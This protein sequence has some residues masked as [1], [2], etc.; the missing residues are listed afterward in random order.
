MT[1][2]RELQRQG[3]VEDTVGQSL[4]IAAHVNNSSFSKRGA[5]RVRNHQSSWEWAEVEEGKA[6]RLGPHQSTRLEQGPRHKEETS[7]SPSS[8][9]QKVLGSWAPPVNDPRP[10]FKKVWTINPDRQ[11]D[12]PWK[13]GINEGREHT[14]HWRQLNRL[15]HVKT[16]LTMM[17]RRCRE[18]EVPQKGPVRPVWTMRLEED[19][20]WSLTATWTNRQQLFG[21]VVMVQS[22]RVFT[23]LET[24]RCSV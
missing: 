15:H 16:W 19:E 5:G 18:T 4:R 23:P 11:F 17:S 13:M 8:P 2:T 6:K 10:P 9:L 24:S 20:F 21:D 3:I 7:R 1:R 14:L 22:E 12:I